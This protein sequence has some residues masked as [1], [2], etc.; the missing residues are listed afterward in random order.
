MSP[1]RSLLLVV[2]PVFVA[3]LMLAGPLAESL[4]QTATPAAPTTAGTPAPTVTAG[5]PT[6]TRTPTLTPTPTATLTGTEARLL[7][8]QTY[9]AGQDYDRAAELFEEI[10]A[11]NRGNT[12]AL[13]GLAQALAGRAA[14]QATLMAPPPL[15]TPV[16]A[17]APATFRSSVAD[18]LRDIGGAALAALLV[19]VALYFLAHVL[20]WLLAAL[21][22]LWYLR[23]LPLL[24]RAAVPPG[25]V[26]GK[27]QNTLG[28]AG[29]T[30]AQVVPQAL[31]EKLLAWNQLVADKQIPVEAAP[32][33]QLGPMAWISIFWRWLLPAPRGYRLDGFLRG[34]GNSYQLSIQ[35]A[36]LASNS[37]DRSVTFTATGGTIEVAFIEMAGE[38][39]KWLI[40]PTDMDAMRPAAKTLRELSDAPAEMTPSMAFDRAL[41]LLLPVRA[42]VNQGSIDFSA[43][44]QRL[45]E[46]Q[47]MLQQL[48][49]GS[50]LRQE[51]DGVVA[52]L[53]KSVPG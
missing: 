10:A 47:A 8:A 25:Y 9:L 38:A 41:E 27:F 31:T 49:S 4:A 24:G 30:A 16:P 15:E 13:D 21:R 29:E 34:A 51:L 20:R 11:E 6:P 39:A 28:T 52:N 37:I 42:Q 17:P 46:A 7:L 2:V 53:R 23:V 40:S 32:A 43:A 18:Q 36:A 45:G 48:P 35:R 1:R 22:E 44:R 3:L 33:L 50:P 12:A 5:T 19:L 14:I 26:I